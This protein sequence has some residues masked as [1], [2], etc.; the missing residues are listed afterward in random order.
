ML[1]S[2]VDII[3]G[4]IFKNLLIYT[5]P[6][7]LTGILQLLY[8]A[9]DIIVVGRYAGSNSL[10][11]V[12]A[13][14]SLTNLFINLFI[15]LAT[16]TNVCVAQFIG[17]KEKDAIHKSV[18]TS[19]AI[20]VIGGIFLM[21]IGFAFSKPILIMM[22]TPENI[23]D[24]ASLYMK[25]IFFGM[26]ANMLYNYGSAIVRASGDTRSP[27]IYLSVSGLLNIFLN[28]VFVVVFK[29]GAA[30]VGIATIMSQ[31]LSASLIIGHL[32]KTDSDIK[33][34]PSKIKI[35]KNILF[36]ILK[37]G[38]PTGIQGMIVSISHMLTQSSINSFGAA[39]IAANS[40]SAN[41]E[42]FANVCINSTYQAVVTFTGQNLGAKKY[43]RIKKILKT[44]YIQ[45]TLIA[46]IIVCLMLTFA[47]PL[48][49]LYAPHNEE[50]I[51][52]GVRRLFILLPFCFLC[53]P[54]DTTT[55]CS[56]GMGASTIPMLISIF[57]ICG[58]RALWI[59][60]VFRYFYSLT[61]LYISFPVSWLITGLIQIIYCMTLLKKYT[62]ADNVD[63]NIL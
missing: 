12:G 45:V 8:N 31:F 37:I 58:I 21:I 20:S 19:I 40:A 54:M 10:A 28:L 16:G 5:I 22:H 51:A 3:N 39:A 14:S 61:C 15:G 35:H 50:V 26:P 41:V 34:I 43:E 62:S 53:G 49:S 4:K 36:R 6:I 13:T 60:T 59:F 2:N 29:L 33:L 1:K 38:I 57:G 18:H 44:G 63:N 9:A 7:M 27:L 30:G 52:I 23:L 56:R 48:I 24:E 55:A 46:F 47:R 42:G 11:A 32:I 25:I 17:A